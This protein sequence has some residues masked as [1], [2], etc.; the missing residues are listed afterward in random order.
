MAAGTTRL[1]VATAFVHSAEASSYLV[2]AYY[3]TYLMRAPDAGAAGWVNALTSGSM[4]MA[5]V[6]AAFLDSNE[7]LSRAVRGY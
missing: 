4:S 7:F 6:A 3:N 1:A 5:N 2:Q